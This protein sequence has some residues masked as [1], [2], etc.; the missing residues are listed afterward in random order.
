MSGALAIAAVT[1]SLKDLLNDGL[2]DHDLSS[3]GSFAVTA[4]PPDRVTTGT[5][6]TTSSTSF[7]T[8]SRRT[9]AGVTSTCRRS[10]A[11]G[12]A[13]LRRRSPSTCTTC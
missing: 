5:A 8:R 2:M 6:R 1:A 12:G 11:Q 10:T 9:S 4:Q 13:L 7:C 3:I